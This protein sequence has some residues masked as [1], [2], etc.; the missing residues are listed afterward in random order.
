MCGHAIRTQPIRVLGGSCARPA[1]L[2]KSICEFMAFINRSGKNITS[3]QQSSTFLKTLA[4]PESLG[5]SE[6]GTLGALFRECS[7]F[8]PRGVVLWVRQ[9]HAS[10]G[11]LGA[12]ARHF[13]CIF[14]IYYLYVPECV[15]VVG[16]VEIKEMWKTLDLSNRAATLGKG[17]L[18][19]AIP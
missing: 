19:Y 3:G 12:V 13:G 1:K 16:A 2:E 14:L 10:R 18:R 7:G 15:P 11:L 5:F 9:R 6:H 17:R 8:R 4:T